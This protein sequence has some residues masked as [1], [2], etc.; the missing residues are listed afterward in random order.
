MEYKYKYYKYK[1]KYLNFKQSGGGEID[2]LKQLEENNV[3]YLRNTKSGLDEEKLEKN[4]DVENFGIYSIPEGEIKPICVNYGDFL[5]TKCYQKIKEYLDDHKLMYIH[6]EE[7]GTSTSFQVLGEFIAN[8]GYHIILVCNNTTKTIFFCYRSNSHILWRLCIYTN[9]FSKGANYVSATVLHHD[10]N[11]FLLKLLKESNKAIPQINTDD[12]DLSLTS[13]EDPN[14][15]KILDEIERNLTIDEPD[16][17]EF[18]KDIEDY[19]YTINSDE[20]SVYDRYIDESDES[21]ICKKPLQLTPERVSDHKLTVKCGETETLNISIYNDTIKTQM[22][23]LYENYTQKEYK[24]EKVDDCV[25]TTTFSKKRG[26]MEILGIIKLLFT[27][28][29]TNDEY[30]MIIIEYKLI[31]ENGFEKESGKE[32]FVGKTYL[33]PLMFILTADSTKINE[34]G[35]YHTCVNLG[36]IVCKPV[37]YETQLRLLDMV[38]WEYELITDD[39]EKKEFEKIVQDQNSRK[40]VKVSPSYYFIG[41]MITDI[42]RKK[43]NLPEVMK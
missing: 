38:G 14:S 20:K 9:K 40:F 15:P 28:K 11:I 6:T 23:K 27:E 33:L 3:Q 25:I 36:L 13:S 43:A 42:I 34:Y 18:L 16:N 31:E 24:Y 10:F 19:E 7:N 32:K 21:D 2:R 39:A 12:F 1:Q 29:G 37:E 5:N 41:D 8:N 17:D 26:K 30:T 35:L 22:D 4:K